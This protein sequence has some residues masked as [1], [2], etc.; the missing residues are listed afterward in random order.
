MMPFSMR[1]PGQ[2]ALHKLSVQTHWRATGIENI[3]TGLAENEKHGEERERPGAKGQLRSRGSSIL[4]ATFISPYTR[5]SY[6]R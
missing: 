6:S 2:L 1:T 3:L 4:S 5:R